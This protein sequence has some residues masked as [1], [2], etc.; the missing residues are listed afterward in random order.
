MSA[1]DRFAPEEWNALIKAPILVGFAAVGASPS[2]SLGFV[3][4]M[5]TIADALVETGQ[6]V[7][8]D[9]LVGS[10]VAEI[11]ANPKKLLYERKQKASVPQAKAKA[12]ETCRR[13]VRIL[14]AKASSNEVIAY[15]DW[16]L[17]VGRKVAE[18]TQ[19]GDFLGFG[20]AKTR[21]GETTVLNDIA[22]ALQA[23]GGRDDQIGRM[24]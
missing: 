2:G 19:R 10:V 6:E 23:G 5:V 21:E 11:K 17:G 14:E 7:S 4:E 16:L 12:L 8:P 20:A 3:R 13:A 1:K 24:S 15:K 9:S 22:V 18:T